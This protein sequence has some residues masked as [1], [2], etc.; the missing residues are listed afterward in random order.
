ME[1]YLSHCAINLE[2]KEWLYFEWSSKSM[3]QKKAP[4]DEGAFCFLKK[5]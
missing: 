4:S 2:S 1:D 3:E 5:V